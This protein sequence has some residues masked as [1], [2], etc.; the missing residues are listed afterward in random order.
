VQAT[1]YASSPALPL[2]EVV[3]QHEPGR[4]PGSRAG[5]EPDAEVER[6]LGNGAEPETDA[7]ADDERGEDEHEPV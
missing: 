2:V 5:D 6:D 4:G 7:D 3:D 1:A